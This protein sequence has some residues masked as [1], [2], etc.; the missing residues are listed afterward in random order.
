[1]VYI[2]ASLLCFINDDFDL[3][4]TWKWETLKA[5][6]RKYLKYSIPKMT[7]MVLACCLNIYI[8]D[9]IMKQLL[10]PR[11][12]M[13]FDNP[14]MSAYSI[15]DMSNGIKSVYHDPRPF[16]LRQYFRTYW[17]AILMQYFK[18][19]LCLLLDVLFLDCFGWLGNRCRRFYWMY[20]ILTT[21]ETS[22]KY[23]RFWLALS[24]AGG[25]TLEELMQSI[26]ES[27]D[28]QELEA[29]S[30]GGDYN[31]PGLMLTVWSGDL[32]IG[33]EIPD[34]ERDMF[35]SVL[36]LASITG[37]VL[38]PDILAELKRLASE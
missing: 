19:E 31:K 28:R 30:V 9:L 25:E 32:G 6:F 33:F 36:E 26:S 7:V 12:R 24:A 11:I 35:A 29:V 18:H 5:K 37:L 16:Y 3:E 1:M 14:D 17:K 13:Y 38:Q 4:K 20:Q 21:S 2:I 22:Q 8:H 23:I 34:G 27:T 10:I 15:K